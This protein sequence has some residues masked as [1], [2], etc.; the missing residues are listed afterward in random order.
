MHIPQGECKE[1]EREHNNPFKSE[2]N[3][4]TMFG[5]SKKNK[6][7]EFPAL[8]NI[9]YLDSACVA[10][11]PRQVI[12]KIKEYYTEYPVCQGR[13]NHQLAE[14]LNK[15]VHAARKRIQKF[16]NAKHPEEIIF[17]RNT[18]EAINI[19]A[20]SLK[21][22]DIV[23]TTDKEHNS[24]LIPWLHL[25]KTKGIVHKIIQ[26]K[27]D[28]TFDMEAFKKLLD[29]KIK[30]ISIVHTSNIDGVTFPVKEIIKE[31]HKHGILVMLDGA[32]S[33]GH[34]KVNLQELDVDF[35]A[36]SGHKMMGPS[37]IGLL[38]GKK[39]LLEELPQ[40]IV[41][42]E[43]VEYSTYTDFKPDEIPA[44]FEAGLQDYSGILGFAEACS[45]LD[46][47]GMKQIAQK[48]AFLNET[49]T[50]A[51]QKEINSGK[52]QLIGPKDPALRSGIFNFIIPGMDAH[53][54]SLLLD[55]TYKIA[56]R[57]GEHCVHSW[58]RARKVKP[59]VRASFYY[60]NTREDALACAKA[61][62]EILEMN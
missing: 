15:E 45:Y 25:V 18:T 10:M 5:F 41:G 31:A 62:Q 52:I 49:I 51:L 1:E 42:G 29:K 55:K 33:A 32:H 47:I 37:G 43:T 9:V 44:K 26:T 24:N 8:K 6:M 38:Y 7:E 35:F 14:R 11:K 20:N 34:K 3:N 28:N 13:S 19:V 2:K 39:K 53:E 58:Y 36:C 27:K 57:S 54:V 46:K 56:V 4:R 48:D 50:R 16:F 22:G 21:K 17:T 61:I 12:E 23:L 59:S 40:F 30:L 60:Y